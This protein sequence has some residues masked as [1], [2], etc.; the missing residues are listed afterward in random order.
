MTPRDLEPA[1]GDQPVAILR[2][3]PRATNL[4]ALR[5][6]N[7]RA[8]AFTLQ[9]L[10]SAAAVDWLARFTMQTDVS[11]VGRIIALLAVRPRRPST[12]ASE[13]GLSRPATTRQLRLLRD[14]GLVRMHPSMLDGRVRLYDLEPRARGVI[15]AWL[16]G[17]EVGR[18]FVM[19][20]DDR[21]VL[22]DG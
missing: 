3:I 13:I 16:A 2:E 21:G 9:H 15:T 17:T 19:T 10:T 1:F 6:L 11:I 7:R 22:R 4:E 18:P 14:A 12:L 8:R 5:D 20:I